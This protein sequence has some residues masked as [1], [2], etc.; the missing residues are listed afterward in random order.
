MVVRRKKRIET[1]S[2]IVDVPLRQAGQSIQ[3]E[4]DKL[5]HDR[6]MLAVFVTCI[7][8]AL[9]V[10]EWWNWYRD[11]PRQPW[12]V[13]A[14]ACTLALI[15]VVYVCKAIPRIKRLQLGLDGEIAV[16]QLLE[17]LRASGYIVLHDLIEVRGNKRFNIDH[18]LVGPGG[19]FVIETKTRSKPGAG[20]A[21]VI[22]D[23]KM[24]RV[25]GGPPD[26]APINQATANARHV[27]SILQEVTGRS[28]IAVQ[29]VVLYPGWYVRSHSQRSDV[30][31]MNPKMFQIYAQKEPKRLKSEDV[32]LYSTRLKERAVII[33]NHKK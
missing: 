16:G 28:G 7:G 19:I 1:R 22:Y 17:E 18:V 29:G 11:A 20:R 33:Q 26:D 15:A 12:A 25:G 21:V 6:V 30:K 24:V 5:I 9:A 3:S 13:T 31:V 14:A 8:I 32:A 4:L 23:G 10:F 27:R 2:P